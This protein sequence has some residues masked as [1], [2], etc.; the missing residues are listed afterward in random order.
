MS[1]AILLGAIGVGVAFFVRYVYDQAGPDD[2]FFRLSVT[3]LAGLYA[4][5]LFLIFILPAI[6]DGIAKLIYGGSSAAPEVAD[7]MREARLLLAKGNYVGA[8]GELR[9]VVM[10]DPDN[11][12]AW[13]EM[14]KIQL[15]HLSDAEG[16]AG[17]MSEA[18]QKHEWPAEDVAFLMFRL[19]ELQLNSLD[20]RA[21]A[22]QVLRQVS[23]SFPDSQHSANATHKLRELG[24]L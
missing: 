16:A 17:T 13:V 4:G 19:A 9:Q 23:E 7:P 8:V 15:D 2:I 6:S 22:V 21:S 5:L 10:D 14:S 1:K 20:D 11:R 24:A 12:L 3:I 18:I